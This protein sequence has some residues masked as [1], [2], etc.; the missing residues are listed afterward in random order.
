MLIG[1][2]GKMGSGKSTIARY[3]CDNHLYNE[4]MFAYP[5]K[6][7]A[8]ELFKA[9]G[10]EKWEREIYQKLGR[11]MREIDP[12]VWVKA[13]MNE[14]GNRHKNNNFVISDVRYPNEAKG[15][16]DNDGV[17]ILL[18]VDDKIRKERIEKRDKV[19]INYDEWIKMNSHESETM[20]D[21]IA[22]MNVKHVL[23]TPFDDIEIVMKKV[24]DCLPKRDFG[25][26]SE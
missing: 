19:S 23:I 25:F 17:V 5:L 18:H 26:L 16:I 3:L 10:K 9:R 4:R 7:I 22:Q 6:R 8:S 13:T 1:I 2:A 14:I 11:A 24:L 15:I 20:V 12:D 21:E